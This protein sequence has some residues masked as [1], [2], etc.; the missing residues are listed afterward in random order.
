MT[1]QRTFAFCGAGD[2]A[3]KNDTTSRTFKGQ[4]VTSLRSMRI[5]TRS[6]WA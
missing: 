3:A 4:P 1:N 6:D 2:I 5:N